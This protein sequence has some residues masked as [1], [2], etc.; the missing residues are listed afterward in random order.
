MDVEPGSLGDSQL[1][2]EIY[3]SDARDNRNRQAFDTL[4]F[5]STI[6]K[7]HNATAIARVDSQLLQD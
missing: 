3:Q 1:T 7:I 5:S 6:Y 4:R 2:T